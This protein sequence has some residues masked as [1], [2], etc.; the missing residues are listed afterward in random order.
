VTLTLWRFATARAAED[1]LPRL[2]RL[3]RGGALTVDDAALVT[4]PR[5][6]RKP[7]T[8]A[9]GALDGPGLLWG[10]SWGILL[11]LI[12]LIPLAGPTFGA[13]AGAVAGGLADFGIEDDFL[14]RA[15]DAVTP[16]TSA[17]FLMR[18]ATTDGPLAAALD[19]LARAELRAELTGEQSRHLRAALG[20]ERGP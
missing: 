3:V 16:G 7:S 20:E 13:A 9:L 11:G 19:G 17:L 1:A 10:G 14:K 15:R 18:E 6:H 5:G 12:F 2:E 4:W 8:R